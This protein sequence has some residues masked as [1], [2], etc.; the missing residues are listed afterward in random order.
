MSRY[1]NLYNP[2]NLCEIIRHLV[3]LKKYKRALILSR[4][5]SSDSC[6]GGCSTKSTIL[7]VLCYLKGQLRVDD[8]DYKFQYFK[9]WKGY[10][11][12]H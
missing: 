12:Q 3:Y 6:F 4:A 2:H 9:L 8:F 11:I 1:K 5:F 10:Y 7:V